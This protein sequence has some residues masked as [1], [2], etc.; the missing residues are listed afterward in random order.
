[1]STEIVSLLLDMFER[2]WLIR[3]G[4][5]PLHLPEPG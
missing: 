5:L 1:M 2:S 3:Q 4:L